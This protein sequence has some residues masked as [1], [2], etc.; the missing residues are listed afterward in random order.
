MADLE[1]RGYLSISNGQHNMVS[2]VEPYFGETVRGMLSPAE[3]ASYFQ[4]V[5]EVLDLDPGTMGMQELLTFAAWI[6]DAGMVMQP[7]VAIAAAQAAVHYYNPQLVCPSAAMCLPS[8]RIARQ[9]MQ[10]RS[11]AHYLMANYAK[12]AEI[13][14]N[15]DASALREL[16]A[17]EYASWAWI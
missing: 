13:L 15:F 11:R 17:T 1:L 7:E 10:Q 16:D 14:E 6:N 8:H 2:F 5:S 9:A 12:A 4:E 3:K